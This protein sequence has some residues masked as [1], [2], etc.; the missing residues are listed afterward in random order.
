MS[1][2]GMEKSSLEYIYKC[3]NRGCKGFRREIKLPF[4][5]AACFEK[6]HALPVCDQC[7]TV[8]AFVRMDYPREVF[9]G[10]AAKPDLFL[11]DSELATIIKTAE[12]TI[13]EA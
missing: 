5:Q 10:L 13:H 9:S 2:G 6:H 1:K 4:G 8:L 11:S 7:H 12:Q 3:K